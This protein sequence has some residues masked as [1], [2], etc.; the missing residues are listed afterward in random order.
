MSAQVDN[1]YVSRS[2]WHLLWRRTGT[3][4]VRR[5]VGSNAAQTLEQRDA[6]PRI[7]CNPRRNLRPQPQPKAPVRKVLPVSPAHP[8]LVLQSAPGPIGRQ[9]FVKRR[10]VDHLVH[11]HSPPI[12]RM[13][14]PHLQ[15]NRMHHGFLDIDS[16]E[17]VQ[18][19]IETGRSQG[20]GERIAGNMNRRP[21]MKPKLVPLRPRH[22]VPP[23]TG[24]AVDEEHQV[25]RLASDEVGET[26]PMVD[27]IRQ[28]P[29]TA[30]PQRRQK[31][32]GSG[33]EL[34]LETAQR[35]GRRFE[36]FV[37]RDNDRLQRLVRQRVI[38]SCLHPGVPCIVLFRRD[39]HRIT[40]ALPDPL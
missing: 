38:R 40:H 32:M 25:Q 37:R 10:A 17:V 33:L 28:S 6:L 39:R 12:Q 9:Q 34:R 15:F 26:T 19:S 31:P 29:L 35:I 30:C 7:A 20:A 24:D 27:F 8:T 13:A 1:R 3:Q 11:I 14:L 5:L 16:I 21:P 4:R 22:C 18:V 23:G 2:L 36:R